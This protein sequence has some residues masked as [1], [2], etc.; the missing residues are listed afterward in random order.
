MDRRAAPSSAGERERR[1]GSAA[2]VMTRRR[3]A[4]EGAGPLEG[5]DERAE[6]G[7]VE[8][9]EAAEVEDQRRGR[10]RAAGARAARG[11]GGPNRGRARRRRRPPRPPL[12]RRPRRVSCSTTARNL[13]RVP[14][15]AGAIGVPVVEFHRCR[16]SR[17]PRR[18]RRSTSPR[19]STPAPPT[20]SS[21]TSR[22][23]PPRPARPAATERPAPAGGASTPSGVDAALVPPGRGHRPRPRAAGRSPS[24][25]APRRASRSASRPR[26]PRRSPTRS[27]RAPRCSCSPPRPWP[28]T[29]CGPSPTSSCPGLVAAAYDGDC[30]PEE[31]TWVRANANVLLT[32]PEMLHYALLPHHAPLG[33]FLLR[34]RYVVVDELHAFRGVFGTHVAHVLRRLRRVAALYGVVDPTFI[35][36]VGHDRRA[37]PA[38]LGAVRARRS[39]RSPTTARRAASGSSR[40]GTRRCSTT[41]SGGARVSP[42]AETAG[43][44]SPSWS[45]AATGPSPSAAAARAP[46]WSPPTSGAACRAD[47]RRPVR[48]YRGGYLAAERREIEDELFSGHAPRR[49]R[50]HRPRA[51]RRHRRP[52]RLRA[53]RLPRHHRLVLAA[54]RPGRPR[55]PAESLAVLVAGDDQLDQWLMR[56]PDELFTRPPEPAVINPAN[57]FVL[58]PHL[59]CAAFELPLTHDDERWWPRRSSTTACATW[60]STTGCKVRRRPDGGPGGGVGRPGLPGPRRRAAQRLVGR[61]PHRRAPTARWSAPSTRPGLRVVHPGAVYLHQGVA[62]RVDR[63]RPRR[64]RRHRRARPT[65]TS[66]R[67][68]A[69]TSRSDT[70]ARRRR[71][72]RSAPLA[73][74]PR[75]RCEVTA[76][77]RLPAHGRRHRRGARPS[78]PRPAARAGSSPGRSGTSVDR[79]RARRRR[80]RRRD[81]W[82][83]TLHAVEHAAI[84][85]LP[86]FT[87][88]DRWDVGGVSTLALPRRHRRRRTGSSIYDGYPGGAGIA[89]LGFDAADRHLAA[90]LEVLG[91][92]P[93]RRRLPVVRAVAEV[94]QLATSRSTRPAPALLR[95]CS[96]PDLRP[97]GVPVIPPWWW[98]PRPCQRSTRRWSGTRRQRHRRRRP[99]RSSRS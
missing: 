35:G 92:V 30:S 65:A 86:L 77:H 3:S 51:R 99:R 69:P 72:R 88:C 89:E 24:P 97:R 62:W 66:T 49:R 55:G 10:R 17:P 67:R 54:G 26:S 53:R 1:R 74:A 45:A 40:C 34:L 19:C 7:R 27:G 36:R 44:R 95:A 80:H 31:R 15:E 61:V 76:G 9:L 96:S 33:T 73:P 42:H 90:T 5:G 94:R 23:C 22:R 57:P 6:P 63:P 64:P 78:R 12:A 16:S 52:R 70:G 46:R 82:P 14:V 75:V 25:P 81:R 43:A 47:L 28:R 18:C 84:G 11:A 71:A 50:H 8:E 83:G 85:I 56:H 91:V 41:T 98:S 60:C 68:P 93:V 38:G 21:S 2:R 29:S 20:A 37:R 48:P 13:V 59:A 58:G 87:I 32:N 39:R 79:G 4:P